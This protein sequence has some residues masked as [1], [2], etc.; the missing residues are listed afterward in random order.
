L[1]GCEESR[2]CPRAHSKLAPRP[3]V[4]SETTLPSNGRNRRDVP[5]R[6]FAGPAAQVAYVTSHRS[7][8]RSLSIAGLA[9]NSD[10]CQ[11]RTAPTPPERGHDEACTDWHPPADNPAADLSRRSVTSGRLPRL[12]QQNV[13]SE[14]SVAVVVASGV[15]PSWRPPVRAHAAAAANSSGQRGLF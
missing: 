2:A 7:Q 4:V 12:S 5:A 3:L 6:S 10:S 1:T 8:R 9:T 15:C 11:N 13:L 14:S